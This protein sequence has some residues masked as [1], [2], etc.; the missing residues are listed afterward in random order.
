MRAYVGQAVRQTG[1]FVC[2]C[3]TKRI[4]MQQGQSLPRCP[5][6]GNDTYEE[7]RH[8]RLVTAVRLDIDWTAD[9]RINPIHV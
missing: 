5:Q 4:I 2:G 1:E 7:G 3:C 6:C 9:S 8:R